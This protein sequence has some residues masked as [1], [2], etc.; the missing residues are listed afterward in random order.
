MLKENELKKAKENLENQTEC[1]RN[2]LKDRNNISDEDFESYC[3]E[4]Q[5]AL[6]REERAEKELGYY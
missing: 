1:F 5:G 6:E 3:E 2:V 4:L